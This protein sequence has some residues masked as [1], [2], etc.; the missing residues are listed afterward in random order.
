MHC[1]DPAC[2]SVCMIGA[3]HKLPDSG[4][5]AYDKDRCI[6]CRYCQI[7]CP[8]DV[9]KFEWASNQPRIVKC[10]LCRERLQE[11]RLPGCVEVCPRQAV[12]FGRRSELLV[13]AH[14]RM[15]ANPD[16]YQH[17]VYGE[18]D[19]GGT[20]SLYLSAVP[21]EAFRLPDLG[22]VAPPAASE[23]IQHGIYQGFIAPV[24]LYAALAGVVLRNRRHPH[25]DGER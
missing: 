24:A 11:G 5:V 22:E 19:G 6:G 4:I 14:R 25:D 1:V 21:F 15:D 10:E 8:F 3:L 20:Q 2:V 17:K 13:E 23:T 18:F 16:R 12:I 7:A 9:P